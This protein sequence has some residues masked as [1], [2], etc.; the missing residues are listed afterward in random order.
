MQGKFLGKL[1]IGSQSDIKMVG[2]YGL[3]CCEQGKNTLNFVATRQEREVCQQSRGY[4]PI[5][6]TLVVETNS[7][8]FSVNI[9]YPAKDCKVR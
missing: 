4:A 1:L 8:R 5:G 7:N 6:Q 3:L 2:I 9:A